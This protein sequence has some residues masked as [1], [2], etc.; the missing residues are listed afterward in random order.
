MAARKSSKSTRRKPARKPTPR[1]LTGKAARKSDGK[2][3]GRVGVS[4]GVGSATAAQ[5]IADSITADLAAPAAPVDSPAMIA[6]K[7]QGRGAVATIAGVL[8]ALKGGQTTPGVAMLLS[9]PEGCRRYVVRMGAHV[10]DVIL[11]STPAGVR[12]W[13]AV[14]EPGAS[15]GS[16]L[17]ALL[18]LGE[19]APPARP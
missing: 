19:M 17:A 15:V 6:Y 4:G 9:D 8:E 11:E 1:T 7:Q 14:A 13:I 5:R 18:T 10:R 3:V 16:T 12:T 2:I